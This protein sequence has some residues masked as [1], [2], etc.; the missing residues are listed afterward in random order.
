AIRNVLG[1]EDIV[2]RLGGDE[3]A[4]ILKSGAPARATVAA[5]CIIEAIRN[6]GF[7]WDGRPHSIAASIGLAP[8]RA[9]CGE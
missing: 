2:A 3:F 6:L 8:I 7:S 9:G 5:R 1:P 4:V